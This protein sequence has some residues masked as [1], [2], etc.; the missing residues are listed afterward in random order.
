MRNT[1]FVSLLFGAGVTGLNLTWNID[2][3]N[4]LDNF[5]FFTDSDPTGG[6]VKYVDQGTASSGGLFSTNNNQIYLGADHT[7]TVSVSGPGRNSVRVTSKNAF[8]NGILIA[9]FAHL[10]TAACGIWPAYWTINNDGNPYGEIDII[11]SYDDTG[12]SYVSLHTSNAC[13][14]TGTN[15]TG[16]NVRTDCSLS[17]NSGC[18][19]E[20]TTSQFGA[21]FNSAGGGLYVLYLDDSLKVWVFPKNNV[22]SDITNGS[23]DPS[24]WG[25][26]LFDFESNNGCDVGTNF[27]NQSIIFNLDFCGSGG[28]GGQEWSQWTDC[29][30]S[31]GSSTCEA[32]VATNPGAYV[33]TYFLINSIRL[34]Q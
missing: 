21:G 14:L 26:P 34:Y 10:P 1:A 7:N 2:S 28:A 27:I 19:V 24:G 30:T 25:V 11:E 4:F 22:P 8:N 5:D 12:S 16:T 13:T 18:G 17:G 9:D 3:S 6:F 23:P 15:F 29:S 20:G 33:D 32:Y 31:T